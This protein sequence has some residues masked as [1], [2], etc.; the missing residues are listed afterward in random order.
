MVKSR[1]R[2]ASATVSV[3]SDA[4]SNARWP[5]PLFDSR[6]GSDTSIGNCRSFRTPNATPH[7][8]KAN[9]S[10]SAALSRSGGRPKTSRSM[11]LTA[12]PSRRSR[13]AP[14]TIR[15]R[16]PAA[17]TRR[18]MSSTA[19][20]RRSSSAARSRRGA[21]ISRSGRGTPGAPSRRSGTSRASSRSSFPNSASRRRAS[22]CTDASPG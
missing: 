17:R 11:S 16:P 14:P 3:G 22:S 5:R 4:I 15:A 20:R 12:P 2:A 21:D 9:R 18:A 19:A 13:T 10:A 1:R 8:S 6:R 7:G